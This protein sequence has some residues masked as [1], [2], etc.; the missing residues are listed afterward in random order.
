MRA[1]LDTNILIYRETN[2]VVRKD[3]GSLFF[4][5]DNLKYQKC[6][7][8]FSI[9]E[10][11]RHKDP[12]VVASMET[13]LQNYHVLRTQAPETAAIQKI[14]ATFDNNDNDNIDTAL[15]KEVVADRVDIL[16]SE[17]KKIHQKAAAL[18][19]SDRVYRIE[20]FL[21]KAVIE[22]PELTDYGV[23]SVKRAYFGNLNLADPFFDSF[24]QDYQGFE[25][26]F[27]KKSDETA[28]V[29]TDDQGSMLAF[30]YV[31]EEG[32]DEQYGDIAPAF[33]AKRRLKI[34]T[35]K[36]VS[37]GYKLGER[38]LKIIFDNALRRKVEE[39]YVTIFNKT[40][41]QERLSELLMEWGFQHHGVKRSGSGEE[42][43]YVRDF[44]PAFDVSN[45]S[46]T[47]PYISRKQRKFIVPIYP[48]YHTELLPDSILNNEKPENYIE[49]KPNRNAISK[50]YVSRSYERNLQSGDIIV[51][52]RT[53]PEG[54]VAH[55]TSVTTTIGVVQQVFTSIGSLEEFIQLCRK[56]SVFTE[57]E[58]TAQWNYRP[59]SRPF[60][61]NFLYVH[62]FRKGKRLN[63]SQLKSLGI[64]EQAPRGFELLSNTAFEKL[65]EHSDVDQRF[66]VD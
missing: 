22:H 37:N 60:I 61:V 15:L 19:I 36:V 35:F 55:H 29:C 7:H 58:L 43:V 49:N 2:K 31:K 14:R 62:S 46:R 5:L 32:S 51:F 50:V 66:I 3:I 53:A 21:E 12:V 47:Y 59:S 52:Y 57:K 63:L 11:R 34:G 4:W 30:L 38:F 24:K 65:L 25:R 26:W 1:L 42:Q 39:I 48:D 8:P 28:Y 16:I 41:E 23:L 27:N 40:P 64:I 9:D 18:K 20:Q 44:R 54:T 33:E 6:V 17:D 45:P 10:I 56:R 13:K